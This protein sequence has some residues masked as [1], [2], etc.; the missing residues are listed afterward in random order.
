MQSEA[1]VLEK[2]DELDFAALLE[3]SLAESGI[4]RGD[5]VSGTV[6]SIDSQG[7]IVDIGWK[8]DGIVTRG[9]IERMGGSTADFEVNAEINVAVV[10]LNDNNG[11]LILSAAQA[12]QNED[13]LRA[14]T[15][16]N[17]ETLWDGEITDVNRGGLIVSFGHLR[18]FV[19]ASHV[20]DLPRGIKEEER[21]AHLQNLVGNTIS[22]KVIEVNQ[23]RRRLVFSQ[24]EAE[25]ENR[26]ARKE[27]L[28]RELA[29]G[30]SRKG[31]VSGLCDFGAF[32]D[33]GGA[34]GL[35]HI[36]ELAWR[37]VRH[38][39]QVLAV[40]DEVEVFILHL[41]AQGQRIGLSL[42]RLQPNPWSLVDDIYHIGQ[43]VEGVISRLESF[44]AFI[45]MD[46]G[47]EALLHVSQMSANPDEN[48]LRHLY[49]GQKL[50]MRIIS[51]ESDRQRLGLSLTEVTAA[52]KAQW[53]ERQLELVAEAA[54][55]A[56]R[57]ADQAE[58]AELN[59]QAPQ[60]GEGEADELAETE[61]VAPE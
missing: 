49:E 34:D 59:E 21:L 53:E 7:L 44:G 18:G 29:E 39:S 24:L 2:T 13:W 37:R 30:S 45:S 23:K 11:N 1:A 10:N 35:I 4:E 5:I 58:Q 55:A 19:P 40:G 48:P 20:P 33:L 28:L 41:D 17:D 6:L 56:Q 16:M 54:E 32:V 60:A 43:L 31:V 26:A 36:S 52:E 42:K 12:R 15:L 25:Q 51:I 3:E 27:A 8:Q 9:D 14:E 22:V 47:I 46:P 61:P 57:E 50:L 38:P